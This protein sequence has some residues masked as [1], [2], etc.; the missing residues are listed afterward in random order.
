MDGNYR[1]TLDLRLEKADTVIFLDIP[2]WLALYRVIR[3][4]IVNRKIKRPDLPDFL[5]ERISWILFSKILSYSRK[6]MLLKLNRH[7]NDTKVIILKNSNEADSFL[8][9][10]R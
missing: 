3:R 2:K 1:R 4:R 9:K 8:E 7:A 6:E 10:V 5:D